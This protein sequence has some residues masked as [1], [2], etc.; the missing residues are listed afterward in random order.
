MR[1]NRNTLL[2]SIGIAVALIASA[3]GGGGEDASGE[4]DHDHRAGGDINEDV[5][6]CVSNWL[7]FATVAFDLS[8]SR[9]AVEGVERDGAELSVL[10]TSLASD[11]VLTAHSSVAAADLRELT[12]LSPYLEDATTSVLAKEQAERVVVVGRTNPVHKVATVLV[13]IGRDGSFKAFD[14]CLGEWRDISIELSAA[15]EATGAATFDEA[16]KLVTSR[17]EAATNAFADGWL[18]AVEGRTSWENREPDQRAYAHED[19]PDEVAKTLVPYRI[20]LT[21]T[22]VVE[23][24][25]PYAVCPR[26]Q[27]AL[28]GYCISLS[29]LADTPEGYVLEIAV[30]PNEPVEIWIHDE[31]LEPSGGVGRL[32]TI[33]DLD[34]T[35]WVAI[36]G[37]IDHLAAAETALSELKAIQTLASPEVA[38]RAEAGE[39]SIVGGFEVPNSADSEPATDD[40]PEGFDVVEEEKLDEEDA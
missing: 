29:L 3:C 23:A 19:L 30:N 14:P 10:S 2:A 27:S 26:Q 33:N 16:M 22:A 37:S 20:H 21:S 17:E 38:E 12:F 36:R 9:S 5:G 15:I 31:R 40:A 25:G 11:E 35:V 7:N 4:H 8:P 18:A 1:T 32:L 34:A 28:S 24:D 39:I 13:E 6:D